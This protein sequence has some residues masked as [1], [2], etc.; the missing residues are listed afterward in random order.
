LN[1][2]TTLCSSIFPHFTWSTKFI[3]YLYKVN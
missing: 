1:S 2:N 3:Q